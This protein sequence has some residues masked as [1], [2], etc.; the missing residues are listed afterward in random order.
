[1]NSFFENKNKKLFILSMWNGTLRYSTC[2]FQASPL[3]VCHICLFV[4]CEHNRR[5]VLLSFS[6]FLCNVG[7]VAS[8]HGLWSDTNLSDFFVAKILW[9]IRHFVKEK[10]LSNNMVKGTFFFWEFLQK[11]PTSELKNIW[12]L[13]PILRIFHEKIGPHSPDVEKCFSRI[14]FRQIFMRSSNK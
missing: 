3:F 10:V 14:S 7:G 8:N 5:F 6:S 4:A 9:Q 1:M 2:L 11:L 13:L 12:F